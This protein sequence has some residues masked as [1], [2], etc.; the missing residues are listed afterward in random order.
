MT[1]HRDAPGASSDP[2]P[3]P[4]GWPRPSR[5]RTAKTPRDGD[6]AAPALD[7][8]SESTLPE[9]DPLVLDEIDRIISELQTKRGEG[10]PPT[11]PPPWNVPYTGDG[12]VFGSRDNLGGAPSGY[13]EEHLAAARRAVGNIDEQVGEL[14]STSSLLR[15][16]V[17]AAETEL[18]RI[19]REYQFLRDRS[20]AARAAPDDGPSVPPWSEGDPTPPPP[21]RASEGSSITSG[22]FT[23]I[24]AAAAGGP[25]PVY[26]AFTVDR[27]NRTIDSMKGNRTKLVIWTLFL[28]AVIGI[29]LVLVM[30][31]SPAVNPPIWIAV[32]PLVWIV[33]IPYFLLS[34]R[35]AQRVLQRNHLNLPEAR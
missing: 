8:A 20:D 5:E 19:S 27:Y 9:E 15:K 10:G 17:T 11:E 13:F 7:A 30:L 3:E 12:A 22:S 33:P 28:S 24:R 21:S 16:R 18:D 26:E 34:F 2:A 4:N 29:V 6:A 23:A 32:L 25:P 35:G 31:Y 1:M 14:Q